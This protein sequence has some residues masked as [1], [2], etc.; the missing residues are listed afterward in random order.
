[1]STTTVSASDLRSN[2]SDS[3][4]A[5]SRKNIVIVTR[6]GKKDRAIVDVDM[7]E[8][9]LAANNPSYLATIKK[10]RE[11]TEYLSHQDVFGDI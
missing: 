4:D 9:L 3:L 2:L 10:A 1:M 7:L 8:D 5:V 6:R 11:S